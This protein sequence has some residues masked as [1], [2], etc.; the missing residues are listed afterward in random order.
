MLIYKYQT[1]MFCL[2]ELKL[3]VRLPVSKL[4]PCHNVEECED[5]YNT[6]LSQLLD[7]YAP[8]VQHTVTIQH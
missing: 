6:I 3:K 5:Q 2:D 7:E 8:K 4:G 1:I